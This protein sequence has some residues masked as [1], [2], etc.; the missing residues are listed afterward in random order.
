M[1]KVFGGIVVMENKNVVIVKHHPRRIKYTNS[2]YVNQCSDLEK[3]III[4]VTSR[5]SDKEFANQL[6]PF[7]VGP[8]TGPDG[9]TCDSLEVFWQVGKVFPHHDNN[10]QPSD[11]YFAYR[12]KMY[13]ADE[14]EIPKS[15]KRHPYHKFGYE[16]DDM[17]YW[18]Y[19]NEE[20]GEYE[21]LSYL[22]ARKKVYVP[23]YA[24]LVANSDAFASL[25]KLVDEGK[26]IALLDFDGFNYYCEEAM[27]IRYRAYKLKCRKEKRPV[28]KTEKDFTD[29]KDMRAAVDFA[30][31]PVG[32]AFVLKALLQGD[33]EVVDGKVIDHVGMLD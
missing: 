22:E 11:E 17:L 15:E 18:A 24:K 33:I 28:V 1:Y 30:Y 5:N 13:S 3:R 10:G 14:S 23:E 21:R 32:H 20:K 26:K 12:E 6:S 8:V 27:K 25:K 16:A 29:I 2:F 7:Y 4:D 19:W 9:A 31:T